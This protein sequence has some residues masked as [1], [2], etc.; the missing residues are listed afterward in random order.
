[1]GITQRQ[2]DI[3]EKIITEYIESARP[4]SSQLLEKKYDFGISPASIRI[5]MRKLTKEGYLLQPHT[6]AGRVPTDSGY[7]FFV[8][9]L[10]DSES[11]GSDIKEWFEKEL[12]KERDTIGFFQNLTNHLAEVANTLVLTYIKKERVLFKE[13]WE[14][15]LREPEFEEKECLLNFTELL[16]KLE[17]MLVKTDFFYRV[18]LSSQRAAKGD[19]KIS[20][21]IKIYIGKENP[22][23][24]AENFSMIVS[25]CPMFGQDGFVSLLGPKRM[26][27][28]KNI[29]LLNSLRQILVETE[30]N[31]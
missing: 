14:E 15:V 28:D 23:K 8:D 25:R 29:R 26:D 13:G 16:E 1:M 20:S 12:K 9:E 7:R 5:E 22:L 30:K 24:E 31:N 21:K 11:D 10:L 6:S 2:A 3:L 18:V 4:V 19:L 27:Y 17:K